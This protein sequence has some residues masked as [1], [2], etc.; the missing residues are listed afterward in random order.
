MHLIERLRHLDAAALA[1]AAG[2][3]LRLHHP[4]F[5]AE[6]P[7]GG[8]RLGYGE[9]R[10]TAWSG[11]A[12]LAQDLFALILVNIHDFGPRV[13]ARRSARKSGRARINLEIMPRAALS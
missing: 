1:A 10:H 3:D 6:L 13:R 2:V 12:E 9:A 7:G 5:A 11:H 4:D 8:V